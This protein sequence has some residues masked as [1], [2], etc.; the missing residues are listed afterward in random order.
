MPVRRLSAECLSEFCSTVYA[1]LGP[2]QADAELLADSLV[3]ADL[4]G[5]SRKLIGTNPWSIASP[6]AAPAADAGYRHYRRGARQ[7]LRRSE[8]L[9]QQVTIDWAV[10]IYCVS[11]VIRLVIKWTDNLQSW[12]EMKLLHIALRRRPGPLVQLCTDPPSD[13]KKFVPIW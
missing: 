4:W 10:G 8:A 12:L 11:G 1:A 5:G 3:Q 7:T 9:R 2:S 13:S 6:R